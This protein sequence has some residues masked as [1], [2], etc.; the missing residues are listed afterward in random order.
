MRESV[1]GKDLLGSIPSQPHRRVNTDR[2]TVYRVTVRTQ[3][4]GTRKI[5]HILLREGTDDL[6]G[7]VE[8]EDGCDE[9]QR[10]DKDDEWVSVGLL[11]ARLQK[12]DDVSVHD[13]LV[14][15][16]VYDAHSQAW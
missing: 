1:V 12:Y 14:K 3:P 5:V 11:C 7:D 6:R 15:C 16:N 8:E 9:G 10:E 2:L 13:A 4:K